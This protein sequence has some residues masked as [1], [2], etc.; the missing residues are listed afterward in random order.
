MGINDFPRKAQPEA[1]PGHCSAAGLIDPVEAV[2]YFL[3]VFRRDRNA[4]IRNDNV[5]FI[6]TD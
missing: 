5:G 2:E 1:G 3:A 4:G 6:V